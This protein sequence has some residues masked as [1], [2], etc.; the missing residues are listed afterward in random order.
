MLGHTILLMDTGIAPLL[1]EH[2]VAAYFRVSV[3]T[4]RK[5]GYEGNG[6]KYLKIGASV[7]YRR[8]DLDEWLNS[9]PVGGCK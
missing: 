8:E 5:W 3:Q 6:P 9:R 1:N 7:R 4:V 2:D